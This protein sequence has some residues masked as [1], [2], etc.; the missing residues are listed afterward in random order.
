MRATKMLLAQVFV[1]V[2]CQQPA[3]EEPST[4]THQFRVELTGP[5]GVP[6]EFT[7]VERWTP[8]ATATKSQWVNV[9]H[10]HSFEGYDLKA[11]VKPVEATPEDAD[12]RM[13]LYRDGHES[14]ISGASGNGSWGSVGGM[15]PDTQ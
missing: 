4:E 6:V 10:T 15:Y 11:T 5:E 7:V 3:N 2:N 14:A 1:L 13:T 9:P 8:F 12:I